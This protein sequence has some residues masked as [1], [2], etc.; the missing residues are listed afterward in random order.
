[1]DHEHKKT[2]LE[3]L[4]TERNFEEAKRL[5]QQIILEGELVS[6]RT[7]EYWAPLAD[8]IAHE[9]EAAEGVE[10]VVPFWEGMHGFFLNEVEPVWGRAHKGHIHFRLG[11]ATAKH[12]LNRA[13]AE[14]AAAYEEDVKLVQERNEPTWRAMER[15]GY[16]AAAILERIKDTDFSPEER[17]DF[18]DYLLSPAFDAAIGAV[19]VRS[20]LIEEAFDVI[21]PAESRQ[22]VGRLYFELDSV[23]QRG[24]AFTTVSLTGTV[25]ES[26]LLGNLVYREKV[27]RL[28]SSK[29]ILKADLGELLDEGRRT[30]LVPKGAVGASFGL[31]RLFRNRL[32]PGVE[33]RQTFKLVP[34]VAL[35]IKILFDLALLEWRNHFRWLQAMR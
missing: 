16:V 9:I 30:I 23:T 2:A 29:D 11:F 10:S 6:P 19:A 20:D 34:R 31:I 17:E 18:V 35:T 4:L 25:L 22:E 12:D 33:A 13:K 1:M 21:A 27:T 5:L 15:S 26:L 28:P 32:H 14:F 24:L 8:T 7:D 3:M